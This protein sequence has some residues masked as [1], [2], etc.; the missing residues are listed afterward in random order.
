L[1]I[2][3]KDLADLAYSGLALQLKEKLESHIFPTLAKSCSRLWIV[4]AE[5][6]SLE[7]FL[8]VA[9]SLGTSITLTW[10]SIVVSHRMMNMPTC[11]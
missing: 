8:G 9:R 7:T 11:V 1:N 4:K 10:L 3:D 6:K 2:F 5:L